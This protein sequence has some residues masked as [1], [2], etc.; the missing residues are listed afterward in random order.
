MNKWTLLFKFFRSLPLEHLERSLYSL[1]RQTVK[2][3]EMI[4]FDNN[5]GR[6]TEEQITNVIAEHFD[7]GDWTLYFVRHKDKKKTLSWSGNRVISLSS[8]D[9]F[10]M[11][12]ADMIQDFTFCEKVLAAYDPAKLMFVAP[13]IHWME[14]FSVEKNCDAGAEDL[15]PLRWRENAQNLL[16]NTR[17]AVQTKFSDHDAGGYCTSKRAMDRCGWYDEDLY[18]WGFDQQDMQQ[19][20]IDSQV[21]MVVVPEFLLFHMFHELVDDVRDLDRAMEVWKH[22]RRREKVETL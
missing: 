3:D 19:R 9:T 22:S 11:A 18:G 20:M 8:N 13:W 16:Q 1:S 7:L 4:F 2:P 5:N 10:V 6:Y 14:C 12:R 21:E 15:E 17:N